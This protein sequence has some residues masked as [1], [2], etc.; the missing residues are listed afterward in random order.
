[1]VAAAISPNGKLAA[2]GGGNDNEI[3]VWELAT[4]ADV[5][6]PNRNPLI[7]SGNGANTWAVGFSADGRRIA[8]GNTSTQNDPRGYGPL[9]FTM[10]LPN[11][12]SDMGRPERLHEEAAR[13]FVGARVTYGDYALSRSRGGDD[14]FDAS[15]DVRQGDKVIATIERGS[16]DGNLHH[17]YTFTPDGQTIISGGGKGW[18][19][20]YDLTGQ[21]LGDFVGHEDD[22]W[23]VTPSPDGRLL[24]SGSADQTLRLWNLKTR[25][26]IVTLFNGTDGEWAMWTPQGYYSGSP[27]GDKIV[28]WQLDKGLDQSP[29]YIT[30]KQL[31]D[32]FYRPDIVERAVI[33]ASAKAAVAKGRG[34][35]FSLSD[36][37]KS[38]PPAFEIASP[39]NGN[40]ATASSIELRL[41][42]EDNADPVQDIEVLVNGRQVTRPEFRGVTARVA[43]TPTS[44]RNVEVPLEEGE[45]QI[46]IVVRN[47]VGQT[48]REFVQVRDKPGLLNH[49]STLY[50]LAIGVDRY[51]HLPSTCGPRNNE[52]CN[53]HFAGLDARAFRDVMVKRAGPLYRNV[54]SVLLAHGGDK[55]P[56]KANIEDTL[57]EMLGKA[58]PADTTA[59]FIAGHGV[60]EE[61][62]DEYLFLPEGAEMAGQALRRSTVVPW[63]TFQVALHK[64]L[65]RRLMFADTCH[66]G[67]AYNA[68]LVNDAANANIVVFSATDVETFSWEFNELQH[69]AFT[70]ALIQ[71]LNGKAGRKDGTVTVLGLGEYV[72]EDVTHRTEEKQQPT[73]NI[74]GAKNFILAKQ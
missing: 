28:G 63:S 69:G 52:S 1:V 67:G 39:Q 71:G 41:K 27:N 45:N 24:V 40:H 32:Q 50:V 22:I 48:M 7:L 56:T 35:D 66:S 6:G 51:N 11:D 29:E 2:T 53:L 18:I 31:R 38:R 60:V 16:N 58:G 43:A 19:T 17:S 42:L 70:Y 57:E 9:E 55:A 5:K 12:R 44:E 68:R 13:D 49:D 34:T 74:S 25:E 10:R 36:L 23:A 30:A 4:G 59:L 62:G 64:T 21:R 20:A 14:G 73:F 47:K 65:G 46:R 72:S 54:K 3:R 15:L 37:Q 33:L 61:R 8:W 26:L